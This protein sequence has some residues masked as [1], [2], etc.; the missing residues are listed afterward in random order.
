M[1]GGK[2]R[3]YL[4][5]KNSAYGMVNK[6]FA[7][8]LSF[9]SRTIFIKMLGAEYLG[10]NGLYSNIL[11]L[12]SLSELGIGS[13]LTFSLYE[14]IAKGDVEK[15]SELL[16]FYKNVYRA[17]AFV[18]LAVGLILIP[19]LKYIVNS[20]FSEKDVCI[21]Y[22]FYLANSVA[23]YFSVY[24]ST[25]IKAKQEYYI[26]ENIAT[27]SKYAIAIAQ[28]LA[29]LIWRNFLVYLAIMVLGTIFQN[30]IISITANKR[31]KIRKYKNEILVYGKKDIIN[32]VKST[33]LYKIGQVIIN[34]TDNILI[35]ILLGTIV[36]G[37]YSN[38]SMIVSQITGII[39]ILNTALIASLGNMATEKNAETSNKVFRNLVFMYHVLT[40]FC[41]ICFIMV[42]NDFIT[43]WIGE[44]NLLGLSAVVAIT[45]NFYIQ[46]IINP[47][48]MYREAY[49]LFNEMKYIMLLTAIVNIVLSVILA[50]KFG[51]AGIILATGIARLMTTVWY[52]P[53]ILYKNVFKKDVRQYYAMQIKYFAIA[54]G[55]LILLILFSWS[56]PASIISI[57]G[58]IFLSF[59]TTIAMFSL[60]NFKTTEFGFWYAEIK[61]ILRK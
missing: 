16:N 40:T 9:V 49:G 20:S 17:I 10:V 46:N 24:K 42:F 44:E 38:Y 21:Y 61:S 6:V 60:F 2:S 12:L 58:K 13:V 39:G 25:L 41:S 28:I 11:S 54:I 8:V 47:V 1:N 34:Y 31:Y 26:V 59:V 55:C 5:M 37:Y 3:T 23:S 57:I 32:N 50:I 35:S 45:I 30:I 36:V 29:L 43:I 27:A 51:V 52:E 19:F 22:L 4:V 56:W 48:W 14:P 33:F 15:T 53:R 18:V 7:L